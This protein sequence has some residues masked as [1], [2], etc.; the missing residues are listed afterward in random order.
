MVC[1]KGLTDAPDFQLVTDGC[2]PDQ[3]VAGGR[4]GMDLEAGGGRRE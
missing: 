2:G 3:S 4:R 1:P